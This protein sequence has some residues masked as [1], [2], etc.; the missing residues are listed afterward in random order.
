M[1]CPL[2]GHLR[3]TFAPRTVFNGNYCTKEIAILRISGPCSLFWLERNYIAAENGVNLAE[4]YVLLTVHPGTILV[5]N[6]LDAQFFRLY[7]FLFSTYF[8]LPC[9]PAYHTVIYTE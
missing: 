2:R 5:N 1:Q 4:F 6:Q 9:L 3:I 7:L 8:G